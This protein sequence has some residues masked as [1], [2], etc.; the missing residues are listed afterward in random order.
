[1]CQ[2][3]ESLRVVDGHICNLA[4]HQQRMNKTRLEVFGQPTPLLLNDVFKAIKAP[5]GLA[6]LRFVYDEAGI[7]NISCTPYK[8]KEIHSLRLV[9]ANNIDYRY[10]SV[11][12]SAL[13]Q[14]KEKQGECDEI[15][16]I[17]NNHI[18]DTSYTN[19]AL[20]DGKQ[21]FTPSTPLLQG[22][23]RQS[24]LDRG[25]LQERE[26]LVSDLPNY[27]QIFDLYINNATCSPTE[28]SGKTGDDAVAEFVNGDAVFYQNG[29]W[30]YNDIKKLGDDA[31]GM[32]PIYIGVKGEEKQGMCSGGE[33]YW[34]VSSKAD[35]ASQKATLDFIYWCVTSDTATT[36]IAEEMGFTIPFKNAKAT[37]NALAN[38]A[39]EYAKKGNE[40]VAWDFIYIPSQEWKNNLSSALKGYAAGTEDW[41]AV[42]SA[43]VDGWKTEKEANA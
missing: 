29:T 30:A 14:L 5:S 24:L 34:C 9:T 40:S 27:K 37:K 17:R 38:I 15:L 11:D 6:K 16:I 21:W 10:K 41:D 23:M 32:I 33:N 25:L 22:T 20:Y 42:K 7:H 8:R 26:L 1:M 18:T 4:Y 3:I 35:D 31:L 19:V 39:A 28:L 2:Y 36:A 43:F 12:R 13:N